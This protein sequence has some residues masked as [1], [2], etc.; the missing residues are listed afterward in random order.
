MCEINC[1]IFSFKDAWWFATLHTFVLS[2]ASLLRVRCMCCE[3]GGDRVVVN[4]NDR[5]FDGTTYV[6]WCI[7][8]DAHNRVPRYPN[9]RSGESMR[10]SRRLV[11]LVVVGVVISFG[12]GR[13]FKNMMWCNVSV[14]FF[15]PDVLRCCVAR[16]FYRI[17]FNSSNHVT[18]SLIIL[19]IKEASRDGQFLRFNGDFLNFFRKWRISKLGHELFNS[20]Y[21]LTF[22]LIITSMSTRH[23]WSRL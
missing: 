8:G 10:Q 4:C 18:T 23:W 21:H 1:A 6:S 20:P 16:V 2:V 12:V 7:Y 14:S 13:Y 9:R 22:E 19:P 3:L 17:S 5:A 15:L 11:Q